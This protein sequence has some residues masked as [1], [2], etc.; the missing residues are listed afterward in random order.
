MIACAI[1][2]HHKR[3]VRRSV[4]GTCDAGMQ[5]AYLPARQPVLVDNASDTSPYAVF[6]HINTLPPLCCFGAHFLIA[7]KQ[8]RVL[9]PLTAAQTPPPV[10]FCATARPDMLPLA[11]LFAT[12]YL[13]TVV[14][15]CGGRRHIHLHPLPSGHHVK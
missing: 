15:R 5:L 14:C 6:N 10:H 1:E 12:D 11:R 7:T 2:G 4:G 13:A 9:V 3:Y 8:C